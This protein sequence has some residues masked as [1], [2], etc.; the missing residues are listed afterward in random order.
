[1]A[2]QRRFHG[3]ARTMQAN[4]G[5]ARRDSRIPSDLRHGL[6]EHVGLGQNLAML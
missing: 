4:L 6:I 5:V 3:L 1:M 2:F